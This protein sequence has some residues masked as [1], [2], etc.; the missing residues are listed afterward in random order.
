MIVCPKEDMRPESGLRVILCLVGVM[1]AGCSAF[2][3]PPRAPDSQPAS[4]P[5]I[6]PTT[7]AVATRPRAD[8]ANGTTTQPAFEPK[9]ITGPP[10]SLDI[11]TIVQLVFENNPNVAS[12]REEMIS[13][14]HALEEF[15]ANLSRLEPFTEVR[16]DVSRYPNRAGSPRAVFGEATAGIQKETFEGAIFRIE[17][18]GS[19]ARTTFERPGEDMDAVDEGAGGLVRGRIE[20]PFVGSR[21]RQNRI[22]N[23]AFQESQARKARLNYLSDFR[24]YV[25]N[26]LSY[27][28][29]CLLY[30]SYAESYARHIADLDALQKDERV[31]RE[32]RSRIQTVMADVANRQAQYDSYYAEYKRYLLASLGLDQTTEITLIPTEYQPSPFVE[33]ASTPEGLAEMIDEARANNPTFRVLEDAIRDAELQRKLAIQGNFDI[34]AFLEGTQFPVGAFTFDDRFEGWVVGGGVTVRLND[35]RVL[36]ASRLKAEANIRAFKADSDAVL[37]ETKRQIVA[38]TEALRADQDQRNQLLD[39]IQ[40]K[41]AEYTSR[42]EAYLTAK[43]VLMDQVLSSRSE[44]TNAELNLHSLHY[45]NL[46]RRIRLQAALG[47][48]YQMAGLHV[49]EFN[50]TAPNG[51]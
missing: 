38:E 34:T 44:T 46:G 17:G 20:V 24:V 50:S 27:Y 40:R 8:F 15:R 41:R 23:Q 30:Q 19:A 7:R 43:R 18:G 47:F 25:L 14:D 48:F 37:M 10:Y 12:A 13:A 42:A 6:A 2:L 9:P 33:R 36:K 11:P 45:Y 31:A 4:R 21:V 28:N 22:I 26:A 51:K 3:E 39:L 49:G 35:Q 5:V 16:S 1:L 32:D 29:Q